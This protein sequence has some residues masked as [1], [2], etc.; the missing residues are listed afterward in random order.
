MGLGLIRYQLQSSKNNLGQNL[1]ASGASS[2]S[3]ANQASGASN[4]SG[5]NYASGAS[6][7]SGASSASGSN[8]VPAKLSKLL[9]K[10]LSKGCT[11][12]EILSVLDGL[13]IKYTVDNQKVR[14]NFNHK[15]YALVYENVSE[16]SKNE[17]TAQT[18]INH[19][20]AQIDNDRKVVQA[21]IDAI[22]QTIDKTIIENWTFGEEETKL[23]TYPTNLTFNHMQKMYELFLSSKTT[24]DGAVSYDRQNIELYLVKNN[25]NADIDEL[26]EVFEKAFDLGKNGGMISGQ[27]MRLMTLN[28][29]AKTHQTTEKEPPKKHVT[30]LTVE[31]VKEMYKILSNA[32]GVVPVGIHGAYKVVGGTG[33]ILYE[34]IQRYMEKNGIQ[35]SEVE[36]FLRELH[37]RDYISPHSRLSEESKQKFITEFVMNHL[38]ESD[39]AVKE[40]A[41]LTNQVNELYA[42]KINNSAVSDSDDE[43]KTTDKSLDV[44]DASL[45]AER[46]AIQAEI[47]AA[48]KI[49]DTDIE[50]TFRTFS[51]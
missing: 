48:K 36:S 22:K 3:G 2:S 50:K 12:E 7:V 45:E 26:Y 8:T 19:K 23:P 16:K 14:F 31:N 47:E 10:Y 30:N 13:K 32:T 44:K 27:Q 41:T 6:G 29:F 35:C 21:E 15:N 40:K 17:Q 18:E 33:H 4:C 9:D 46:Q 49:I 34:Q 20:A 38:V 28:N 25:I 24:P 51:G 43:N 11:K 37:S 1:S 42:Q 39:L 5:A